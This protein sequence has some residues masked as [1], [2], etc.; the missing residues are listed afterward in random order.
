MVNR[1]IP[2][3]SWFRLFFFAYLVLP[4]TQGARLFY[5]DYVDPFLAH[6]ER[7]IEDF[8]GRLHDRAKRLGLQYFYQAVEFA[9]EKFLG[10]APQRDTAPAPP[11]GA[12]GYAQSLL[13]RFNLPTAGGMESKPAAPA[14]PSGDWF[15]T[16]GSAVASMTSSGKNHDARAEE[17]S[18]SGTL[19]P[20]EMGSMS[21]TEKAQFI[22]NQQDMLDVLHKAL[23]KERTN[24][25]NEDTETD[26]LAYGVPL[27]KNRSENSFD[28]IE[29]EDVSNVAGGASRRTASGGW[30]SGW[31]GGDEGP[32]QR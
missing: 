5:Q 26:D 3:Y 14:G 16:I 32:R 18:A 1:R 12:A 4:Q 15:S 27:K 22:N 13:S 7:E 25:G 11:T 24:L 9:Q 29:H 17:L 28:R 19:F 8:I 31:F 6:H 30:A 2:F 23:A 21:R 10:R 20:R